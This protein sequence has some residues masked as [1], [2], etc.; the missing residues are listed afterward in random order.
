[1]RLWIY[2]PPKTL[3]DSP[4]S[5]QFCVMQL[6]LKFCCHC[7]SAFWSTIVGLFLPVIPFHTPVSVYRGSSFSS[8][9]F[10]L[11][12]SLLLLNFASDSF[13]AVPSSEHTIN[14]YRRGRDRE[15]LGTQLFHCGVMDWRIFSFASAAD[16]E[17]ITLA[18]EAQPLS[19]ALSTGGRL[20]LHHLY[21]IYTITNHSVKI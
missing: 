19:N 15:V 9:S 8:N 11:T 18:L 4:L 21:P 14:S 6:K 7:L 17:Q 20:H 1:M 5:S 13:L 2:L 12:N 10:F 3:W 16:S